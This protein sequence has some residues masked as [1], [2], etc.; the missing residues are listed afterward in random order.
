MKT[1]TLNLPDPLYKKIS[2]EIEESGFV[3]MSDFLRFAALFY[4]WQKEEKKGHK[5]IP[6]VEDDTIQPHESKM[7]RSLAQYIKNPK[8]IARVI[9]IEH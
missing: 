6:I 4:F 9:H 8:N 3:G 1:T 7:M 2:L 5:S